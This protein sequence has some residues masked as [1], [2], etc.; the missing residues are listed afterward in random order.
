MRKEFEWAVKD[1]L[2]EE[3]EKMAKE[4]L[5]THSDEFEKLIGAQIEKQIK[6]FVK[7]IKIHTSWG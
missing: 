6:S 7:T 2:C 3:Y 4:Y 1:L 5:A